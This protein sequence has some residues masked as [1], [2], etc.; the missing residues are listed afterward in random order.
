MTL[1]SELWVN[2]SHFQGGKKPKRRPACV[3]TDDV[4]PHLIEIVGAHKSDGEWNQLDT[5]S[6]KW[7]IIKKILNRALKR[8]SKLCV[9][10]H[11]SNQHAQPC[12]HV[13]LVLARPSAICISLACRLILA[14]LFFLHAQMSRSRTR[15]LSTSGHQSRP[16]TRPWSS[17][18]E[19]S[20]MRLPRSRG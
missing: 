9:L 2:Y 13:A 5:R 14:A 16:S 1:R 17:R 11:F 12:K 7:Q 18:G 6:V 15:S 20:R 19:T 10:K 8:N 3:W 4:I